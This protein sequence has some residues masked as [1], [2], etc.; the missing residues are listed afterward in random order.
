MKVLVCGSRYFNDYN[1]LKEVLDDLSIDT[2]IH[3]DARGA[4]R[5]AGRYGEENNIP[6]LRFPA[7]WDKYGKRAGPIRNS[8]M[9]RE[10]NPDY[11]VAFLY[12][13]SR[14]T[15][16]MIKKSKDK[17]LEVEIVECT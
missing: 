15:R 3:G 6:V 9:L 4:D 13:N 16:D 7:L 8:Q 1:K 14:G 12:P 5:L 2:I 17:G 10:G 11:V